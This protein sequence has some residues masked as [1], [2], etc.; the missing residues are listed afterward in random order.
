[1][2]APLSELDTEL[3]INYR[4]ADAPRTLLT[5]PETEREKKIG[6][7]TEISARFGKKP[8]RRAIVARET[9]N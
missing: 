9:V 1:M 8:K 4:N 7:T 5:L 6:K 2:A 3:D